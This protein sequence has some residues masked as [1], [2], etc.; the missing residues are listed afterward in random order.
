MYIWKR[1]FLWRNDGTPIKDLGTLGGMNSYF[2]A[3]NDSGQVA[4]VS[5]PPGSNNLHAFVWMND[6]TPM[7]DLGTLGGTSSY[8][9]GIN[10]S[11]QVTG[12]ATLAGDAVS[13]AFLWRNDGKKKQDLNKLIDPTDPLKPY[14][15]LA[16]GDFINDSGDIVAEGTDRRTGNAGLYLLQG[17][18]LALSPR[19]LVF[20]NHPINTSST[21]KSVTV[22]NTGSRVVAITGIAL[23]GT[24]S[25]QF[26]ATNNCGN[27]LVGHT[28]CTIKVTFR[29]T[30]KGVKPAALNI[31]GGDDGLLA[32]KITGTGT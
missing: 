21:A 20:G 24:A 31:N 15:T 29:P 27:S 19:S 8:A 3:L 25:G 4:G 16:K 10:S 13:H 11:G 5:N 18:V 9:N 26:V 32:I 12:Y 23:T 6:G 7:Q 2:I 14:V 17:T 30:T 28:T 22:T 1:A